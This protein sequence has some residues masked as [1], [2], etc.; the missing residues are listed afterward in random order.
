M[1][2]STLVDFLSFLKVTVQQVGQN[3]L[4]M[5]EVKGFST[6]YVYGIPVLL[7]DSA[8]TDEN[9][10]LLT[11]DFQIKPV[12]IMNREKY[13]DW[14][15]KNVYDM[16]KFGRKIRGIKVRAAQNADIVLI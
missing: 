14:D 10:D 1:D 13:F 3:N 6:T 5:I 7:P 9:E 4:L 8:F 11:F 12:E 16:Q 15:V 2:E